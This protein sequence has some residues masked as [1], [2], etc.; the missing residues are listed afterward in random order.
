MTRDR[1]LAVA[2]AATIGYAVAVGALS[3]GPSRQG[4]LARP[5]AMY[6]TFAETGQTLPIRDPAHLDAVAQWLDDAMAHPRSAFDLRVLPPPV[7]ELAVEF[8]TGERTTIHFS[9]RT[10]DDPDMEVLRRIRHPEPVYVVKLEGDLYTADWVPD[11]LEG[12]LELTENP[13]SRAGAY[14]TEYQLKPDR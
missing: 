13:P 3:S 10:S 7:N 2:V 4:T 11:V 6:A 9:G 12:Y 5:V 14:V 8:A 1:A